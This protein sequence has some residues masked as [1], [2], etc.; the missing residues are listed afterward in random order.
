MLKS[1]NTT[2]WFQFADDAAVITSLE[3]ENQI[4]LHH[5][6]GWCNW[7]GMKIRVDK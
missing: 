7:A 5:F 2:H 3:K 6:S 4:L 1:V